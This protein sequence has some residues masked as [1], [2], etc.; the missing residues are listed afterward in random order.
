MNIN[1]TVTTMNSLIK[2]KIKNWRNVKMLRNIEEIAKSYASVEEVKKAIRSLQSR[3]SR[4]KK[5][6]SR[7]DY[8]EKMTEIL[9]EEQLLKEVRD[10]FEPKTIPVTKMSQKDVELLNYEETMKAIKSIQS[11]KC[12]V[13]HAT[14]RIEDNEEYKKA[15]Q[16]EQWLL[17]HKKNIKPIEETVV[18]KSDIND[19]IDHLQ[20]QDTEI[21]TEYV[22]NLLEKLLD[23]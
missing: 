19:L 3:K 20:N 9:Q 23:K 2:A 16:I 17:E 22:I 13:Q 4:L 14:E 8:D 12:N 21:E 1:K 15:C 7:K 10:Y 18:R 6:K 5:Q 11:K